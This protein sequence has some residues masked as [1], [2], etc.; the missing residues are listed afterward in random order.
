MN[1]GKRGVEP[2]TLKVY[3]WFDDYENLDVSETLSPS[4]V[5]DLIK[6][7]KVAKIH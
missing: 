2:V 3:H 1:L 4:Q 7:G 6:Q 5:K